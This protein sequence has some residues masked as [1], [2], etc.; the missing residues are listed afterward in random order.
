MQSR[1][2]GSSRWPG[3]GLLRFSRCNSQREREKE[4]RERRR[5]WIVSDRIEGTRKSP[6]WS[7]ES[8]PPICRNQVDARLKINITKLR[9]ER[10]YKVRFAKDSTKII[11]IVARSQV[12]SA[13]GYYVV[14][15][16]FCV[17][18]T[19]VSNLPQF[20][21]NTFIRYGL[22]CGKG[23]ENKFKDILNKIM[24]VSNNHLVNLIKTI[25]EFVSKL[26]EFLWWYTYR[27]CLQY[28][29]ILSID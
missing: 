1:S 24:P 6:P 2:V 3:V 15:R 26:G 4:R 22:L 9:V 20:P 25:R 12:H 28:Q 17:T 23:K 7:E 10:R 19:T 18:L 11:S 29:L 21:Y 5:D 13:S 14:E 8:L 27:Q 16:I